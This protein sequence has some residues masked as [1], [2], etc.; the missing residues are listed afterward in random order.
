MY[1]SPAPPVA[2]DDRF[3]VRAG[4]IAVLPV[5]Y[6]D[7]DPNPEDILSIDPS[8]L[9]GLDPAFGKLSLVGANQTLVIEVTGAL[10]S[11]SFSYQATDGKN[12]SAV[13]ATVTLSLTSGRS[14]PV[15]CADY[16]APNECFV[17]WP[18]PQIL[19]GGTATFDV[20]KGWIDPGGDAL[21]ID[22]AIPEAGAPIVAMPAADGSFSVM[23]FLP[24]G[25]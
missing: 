14:A 4:A 6:N 3:G 9:S 2:V 22:A 21:V 19:L 12:A 13:G 16:L 7:H 11:A 24:Q 10:D 17:Q 20:L 18:T 25:R 8:S 5:L 23:G 15:W 1:A